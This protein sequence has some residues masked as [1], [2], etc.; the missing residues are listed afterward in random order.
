MET[1]SA[2]LAYCAGNSPVTSSWQPHYRSTHS[3][4]SMVITDVLAYILPWW[5]H[6]MET[7]SV[8]LAICAG[9]SPVSGEFPPERPVTRGFY[10]F[11]DLCPQKR[12][13]KQ[14]WGWWFETPSGP[15][16]RHSNAKRYRSVTIASTKWLSHKCTATNFD[17][18]WLTSH[19]KHINGLVQDC[20]N[21]IATAL[22]LQHSRTI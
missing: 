15:L 7:F 12:L 10:V 1:L 9:N 16:W 4:I 6:Q 8:L 2:L 3:T 19:A 17:P 11:F 18:P 13:S 22:E 14:S 20:S 21:S 5:R